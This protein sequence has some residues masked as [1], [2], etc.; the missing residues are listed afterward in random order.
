MT[1]D[2]RGNSHKAAGRPD[3][4]QFDRKAGQ[5]SDD[6]L[7]FDAMD[8]RLSRA[9]PSLDYRARRRII[10]AVR[11]RAPEGGATGGYGTHPDMDAVGDMMGDL[12]ADMAD[13]GREAV[14][15]RRV[16]PYDTVMQVG[17]YGDFIA[18]DDYRRRLPTRLDRARYEAWENSPGGD[19]DYDVRL[20]DAWNDPDALERLSADSPLWNMDVNDGAY[21]TEME[22]DWVDDCGYG[23]DPVR[24]LADGG[25]RA[26]DPHGLSDTAGA[27]RRFAHG[28]LADSLRGRRDVDMDAADSGG[29]RLRHGGRQTSIAFGA[30]GQVTVDGDSVYSIAEYGS[31]DA[32]AKA[33]MD[34]AAARLGL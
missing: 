11:G 29:I 30:Q 28:P 9:M 25:L 4:G 20:L 21:E 5:A 23:C 32:A 18:V 19:D 33:A 1:M 24:S 15:E 12:Q 31:T 13:E 2:S 3:G 17:E 10:D 22:L 7:D 14:A 6:D 26:S 27:I 8:E 34:D 16:L